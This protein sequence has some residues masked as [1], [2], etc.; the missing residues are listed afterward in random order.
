MSIF[1]RRPIDLARLAAAVASEAGWEIERCEG[2][3][4]AEG[5]GEARAGG[6]ERGPSGS[7]VRARGLR[8]RAVASPSATRVSIVVSGGELPSPARMTLAVDDEGEGSEAKACADIRSEHVP[9]MLPPPELRAIR[10]ARARGLLIR[11]V[12]HPTRGT[13]GD[14][15]ARAVGLAIGEAATVLVAVARGLADL[16]AC[17]RAAAVLTPGC[18]GFRGDGC[19]ILTGIERLRPLDPE[20]GRE[21]LRAFAALA[22]TVCSAVPGGRAAGLLAAATAGGHRCWDDVISAILC[23]ADPTAIV[24]RPEAAAA[25]AALRRALAVESA[26][27]LRIGSGPRSL[28]AAAR[29]AHPRLR[30][31]EAVEHSW[32]LEATVLREDVRAAVSAVTH[33]GARG[34]GEG[35]RREAVR[36]VAPTGRGDDG[37]A[38]GRA[39][40]GDD[41]PATD[42]AAR[43]GGPVTEGAARDGAGR[44]GALGVGDSGGGSRTEQTGWD[45]G[46]RSVEGARWDGDQRYAVSPAGAGS[47]PAGESAQWDRDQRVAEGAGWDRDERPTPARWSGDPPA[48]VP[49][50]R[51]STGYGTAPVGWDDGRAA[52]SA[53]AL[54]S[55]TAAERAAP[56]RR[57]DGRAAPS[58]PSRLG[59]ETARSPAA[60]RPSVGRRAA[61]RRGATASGSDRV[62]GTVE[63]LLHAA[64]DR[65]LGRFVGAARAWAAER[66][67]LVGIALVPL[68]GVLLALV[69]VP[70]DEPAGEV[71]GG[72]SVRGSGESSSALVR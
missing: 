6:V 64:G 2:D 36:T 65:P 49:P 70:A 59:E 53:P 46:A 9:R 67:L 3:A 66:P 62:L 40:W 4:G 1:A 50:R 45:G 60:R 57:D 68:V 27:P 25:P 28:E 34:P 22:E 52:P 69:L 13:L 39:G 19:P 44:A 43:D 63:R 20:T 51:S 12:E 18:I 71:V 33:D 56:A 30:P 35:A 55:G 47:G 72:R 8:G 17:G 26:T 5:E 15:L 31:P 29:D 7:A 10:A 42:G 14:L 37:R 23:A 24:R 58:V 32:D 11:L 48:T 38:M 54:S 41:G 61:E 21:D 16:H